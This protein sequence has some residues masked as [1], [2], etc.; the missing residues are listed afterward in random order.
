LNP[1]AGLEYVHSFIDRLCALGADPA[2]RR[3]VEAL[4]GELQTTPGETV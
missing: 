2:N 4:Y 3:A 1:L